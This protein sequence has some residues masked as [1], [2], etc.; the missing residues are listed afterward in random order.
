MLMFEEAK[1]GQYCVIRVRR[2]TLSSFW[3]ELAP[4][5]LFFCP[6]GVVQLAGT[7]FRDTEITSSN[8]S[9]KKKKLLVWA[10]LKPKF[11]FRLEF[12]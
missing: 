2:Y 1:S 8:L 5:T 10:G 7:M 4:V 3:L 6:L 9:K 11:I 12:G